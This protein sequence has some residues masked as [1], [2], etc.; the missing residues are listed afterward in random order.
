MEHTR[1]DYDINNIKTDNKSDSESFLISVNDVVTNSTEM[2][3]NSSLYN[4]DIVSYFQVLPSNIDIFRE[5]K[6]KISGINN[7]PAKENAHNFALEFQ[8]ILINLAVRN[9]IANKLPPI[10]IQ[11]LDDN[12]VLLEWAFKDFRIGFS[13]EAN[14]D[15]S[16]WF[17]LTKKELKAVDVSGSLNADETKSLIVNILNFVL[18][19]T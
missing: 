14:N 2:F 8:N 11:G 3:A 18:R 9:D 6:E 4:N 5:I 15:D 1:F 7:G 19:N 12:S 16:S 17:L 10:S 13:F